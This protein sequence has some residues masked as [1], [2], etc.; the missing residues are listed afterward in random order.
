MN[1]NLTISIIIPAHNEQRHIQTCLQ[2]IAAQTSQ[3]DEVIVVDNN[4]TDETARL[5]ADFPFVRVI[6]EGQQG[7]VY[8][9]DAG[10]NAAKSDL[11]GRIDADT[12]LPL[13][14][15][16]T[17]RDFYKLPRNRHCALTGTGSFRNMPLPRAAG[18]LQTQLAFRL[19]WLALGHHI[20]WGSNMVIPRSAW[21]TVRA[22]VCRVPNT[23]EDIDLAIHL[24]VSKVPIALLTN[25]RVSAIMRRVFTHQDQLWPNL[26]WW[27]RTLRHH[28]KKRWPLAALGAATV[29]VLALMVRVTKKPRIHEK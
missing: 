5:A 21:R 20:L 23:H 13:D 22:Q 12:L 17:V 29:Y 6:S 19:N 25:L 1:K 4:S 15:V 24:R 28:R 2:A 18:W 26:K 7:I 8:A 11:L 10:F 3:P 27:P 9:R 16:Q 14:W